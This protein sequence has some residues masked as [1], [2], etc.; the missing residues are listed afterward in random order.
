MISLEV[1]PS[2][3]W[4]YLSTLLFPSEGKK[5]NHHWEIEDLGNTAAN[6]SCLPSWSSWTHIEH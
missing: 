3:V 6:G 1:I 4:W 5:K 2:L